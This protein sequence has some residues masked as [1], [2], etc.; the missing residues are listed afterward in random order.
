MKDIKAKR[1]AVTGFIAKAIRALTPNDPRNEEATRTQL[2]SLSDAEFIEAVRRMKRPVT[3]EEKK[4]HTPPS[5]CMPV[6]DKST[7]IKLAHIFAVSKKYGIPQFE[8]V[9]LTDPQTGVTFLSRFKHF[10]PYVT[11]REQAQL[12]QHKQAIPKDNKSIDQ[13]SGQVTGA[14]KGSAVSNPEA[15]TLAAN[16]LDYTLVEQ[17]KARGGDEIAQRYMEQSLMQTGEF[18][19]S[20]TLSLGGKPKSVVV[21]YHQL[22]GMGIDSNL[23]Q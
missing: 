6:F 18:R 20:D 23:L 17:L 21:L 19:L 1:A 13:L 14:S 2:E 8:Q 16:G 5:F 4:V 12:L 15:Q 22:R 3:L 7:R 9:W 10:V 11:V